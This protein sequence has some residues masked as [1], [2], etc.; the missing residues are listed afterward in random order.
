[1]LKMITTGS[2]G[3]P[4]RSRCRVR[5]E[6]PRCPAPYA[7]RS[8]PM[9][10]IPLPADAISVRPLA[11]KK[12]L[13]KDMIGGN[14]LL[15]AGCGFLQG[16]G[17]S[18]NPA[19]P[20]IDRRLFALALQAPYT[21]RNRR[22]ALVALSFPA[23]QPTAR[24]HDGRQEKELEACPGIARNN[25]RNPDLQK[26]STKSYEMPQGG[27]PSRCDPQIDKIRIARKGAERL[28]TEM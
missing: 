17:V 4:A 27:S 20:A 3:A 8:S 9:I 2:P 6:R 26:L 18:Q 1:M 11:K 21:A 5:P 19:L 22:A 14:L 24:R 23:R 25:P 7:D 15:E 13:N 12:V 10:R 16:G 28:N